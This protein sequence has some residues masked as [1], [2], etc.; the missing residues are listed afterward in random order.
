MPNS[1]VTRKSALASG[2]L[3]YFTGEP[4][5]NGHTAARR[6]DSCACVECLKASRTAHAYRLNAAARARGTGN[7]LYQYS[8][9]PDDV[10]AVLAYSQLL[11]AQR[12]RA[13]QAPTPPAPPKMREATPEEVA[14]LIRERNERLGL[15]RPEPPPR[16]WIP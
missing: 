14:E 10:A 2:V 15:R 13:P 12:G 7:V 5:R 9:H 1:I 6:T 8:H 3:T 11:D 16:E 4:C